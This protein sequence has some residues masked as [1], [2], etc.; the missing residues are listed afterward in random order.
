MKLTATA[1]T[2]KLAAALRRIRD[3]HPATYAYDEADML[4]AVREWAAEALDGVDLENA[5]RA[6]ERSAEVMRKLCADPA[7]VRRALDF[8]VS[9]MHLNETERAAL[10]GIADFLLE[11]ERA[12]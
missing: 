2:D 7:T 8:A 6:S 12:P 10:R 1:V 11:M 3:Q 5:E 9:R 4:A